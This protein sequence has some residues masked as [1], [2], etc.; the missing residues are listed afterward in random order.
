MLILIM[1]RPSYQEKNY[2]GRFSHFRNKQ[3]HIFRNDTDTEY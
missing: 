1:M 2:F 3:Y